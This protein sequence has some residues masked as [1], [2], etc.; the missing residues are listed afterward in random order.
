MRVTCNGPSAATSAAIV[1]AR[2]QVKQ[3]APDTSTTP[4]ASLAH[5]MP[6]VPEPTL[7]SSNQTVPAKADSAQGAIHPTNRSILV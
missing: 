4:R 6:G 7:R 2:R 1:G 5:A 3:P